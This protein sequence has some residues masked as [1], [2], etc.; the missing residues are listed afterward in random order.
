MS[1]DYSTGDGAYV[2]VAKR[3]RD[4]R[5][6]VEAA[7]FSDLGKYGAYG[8]PSDIR[9]RSQTDLLEFTFVALTPAM[10]ETDRHI[11]VKVPAVPKSYLFLK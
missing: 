3:Q 8:A 6:T 7:V 5:S 11:V 4:V 2:L 9:L 1:R 10:R